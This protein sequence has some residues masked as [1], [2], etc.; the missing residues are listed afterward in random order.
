MWF[1]SSVDIDD[2]DLWFRSSSELSATG[3]A[4]DIERL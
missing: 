4:A 3:W 1:C 2:G